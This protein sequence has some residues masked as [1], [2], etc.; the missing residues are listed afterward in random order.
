MRI[1]FPDVVFDKRISVFD[2]NGWSFK[3]KW[4]PYEVHPEAIRKL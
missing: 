3:G 2:K 4:K 1:S